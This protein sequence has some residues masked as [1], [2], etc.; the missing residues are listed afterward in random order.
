MSK[1]Q[2]SDESLITLLVAAQTTINEHPTCYCDSERYNTKTSLCWTCDL[3]SAMRE[4][5]DKADL[6]VRIP[7]IQKK[8]PTTESNSD[9]LARAR[10]VSNQFTETK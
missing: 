6:P 1:A 8:T 4:V 3:A 2:I 9:H 5:I 10:R 7:E